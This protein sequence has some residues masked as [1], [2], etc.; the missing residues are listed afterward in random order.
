MDAAKIEDS[1]V[2]KIE[3][4]GTALPKV[5]SFFITYNEDVR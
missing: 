4:V 5:Q 1:R 2:L 3:L